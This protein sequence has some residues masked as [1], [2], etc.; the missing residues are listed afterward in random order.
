MSTATQMPAVAHNA[1][2]HLRQIELDDYDAIARLEAVNQLR[3]SSRAAWRDLWLNSPL[4]PRL[5]NTWPF[6]W[7]LADADE[8]IVGSLVNIPSLYKFRGRDLICANGR[9]WVVAPKCRGFALWLMDEYFNQ[10]GA[11]LFINTTVGPVAAPTFSTLSARMPLGDFET[12][13][14]WVTGY[15]GFTQKA[16]RKLRVP[17]PSLLGYPAAAALKLKDAVFAKSLPAAPA[18]VTIQSTV[19][20]DFRFDEFWAELVRQNPEKLLAARDARTLAWHF[21]APLLLGRLWIY[22]A[23]RNG[24]LRAYCLVKWEEHRGGLRRMR[25]VDY[26]TVEPAE[27][28]LPA[29]LRPILERCAA[30]GMHLLDHLGCGVPKTGS[31]DAFAPYRL[32]QSCWPFY[33]RAADPEIDAELAKPEVWDPSMFDGDAS[34]D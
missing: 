8:Q 27:D 34:F 3:S 14:Y 12:A 31:F 17:L 33:Y 19:R 11:E 7:V 26:Q 18:S 25:L 28:L 30:E 6:G 16:L 23:S 4:W 13:A 15:R 24:L 29:L 2:P 32:K 20:F 1:A 21:A 10:P 5:G 22:T 9:A